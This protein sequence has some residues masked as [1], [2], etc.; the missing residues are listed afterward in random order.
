VENIMDITSMAFRGNVLER[1][2]S[3]TRENPNAIKRGIEQAVPVSLAGLA[4]HTTSEEHAEE[5]LGAIRGGNYPHAAPNEVSDMVADAGSTA[6]LTQSSTGFLNR[7]FGNRLSAIIDAL[8]TQT[9]LSR[10]SASTLLGLAT[11]VVLDAVGKEA[12][13]RNLDARGLSRFLAEQGKR[14]SAAL[15]APLSSALGTNGVAASMRA[16]D[17]VQERGRG[18]V[19]AVRPGTTTPA[20][21]A[22]T[23]AVHRVKANVVASDKVA[24]GDWAHRPARKGAGLRLGMAAA[25][26]VAALFL[27]V[28]RGA[29]PR[30]TAVRA[31][32]SAPA[33][34]SAAREAVR[35][36][37]ARPTP[38]PPPGIGVEML[39]PNTGA[40]A[41][42]AFLAA[43]DPLPGRFVLDGIEFSSNLNQ[44]V[45]K[46]ALLDQVA[47]ALSAQPTAKVRLQGFADPSASTAEN[48][49]LSAWRATAV[50]NYLLERGVNGSQIETGEGA[51]RPIPPSDPGS[52]QARDRR[53]ELTVVAR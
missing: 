40:G 10:S 30:D 6:R 51:G 37:H 41:L 36:E 23:Q 11:P 33:A 25:L 34:P 4:A 15:P 1:L 24:S 26:A 5:L 20:R 38:Q 46:N 42:T 21:M 48:Q 49:G 35:P 3:Q 27:F 31:V 8:A 14:V 18:T 28:R 22:A 45:A 47:G 9:G 53:V 29:T 2:S 32:P 19:S 7:I 52:T 44:P 39:S 16:I 50:K 43:T 12:Q 13:S 17:G